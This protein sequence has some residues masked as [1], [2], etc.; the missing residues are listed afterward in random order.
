M[1]PTWPSSPIT[2]SIRWTGTAWC[3]RCIFRDGHVQYKNRWVQTSHLLTERKFNPHDLRQCRQAVAGAAGRS[4]PAA[5]PTSPQYRQHQRHFYH[6]DKLLAMWEGGFRTC[7]TRTC[8]RW[9]C[10]DYEGALKPGD[11]LTAHPGVPDHGPAGVVHQRWDSPT[12]GC[13]CLTP[14]AG[15][16]RPSRWNSPAR[17]LSTTCRLPI[18][19]SSFSCPGFPQRGKSHE[20]REPFMWEPELGTRI[21]VIPAVA[22]AGI[23]FETDAFFSWH[24]C[25]GLSA[26][27]PDRHRLRLDQFHPLHPGP[28]YRGGENNRAGCIA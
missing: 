26:R 3:T 14:A 16:G 2:M 20:G 27:W 24:Y 5:K 4:M 15:T 13:R 17:A 19:T 11:A 28:G 7:S 22:R 8:R 12:T 21:I 25:N 10:N 9:A 23:G 1:A 18:T 6:G